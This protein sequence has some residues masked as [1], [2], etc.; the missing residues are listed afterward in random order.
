MLH[1]INLAVR[2]RSLAHPSLL[3]GFLNHSDS[4]IFFDNDCR[5]T[6]KKSGYKI[7]DRYIVS[8]KKELKERINEEKVD[9]KR[10]LKRFQKG[11]IGRALEERENTLKGLSRIF[12]E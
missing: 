11:I 8:S 6:L 1:L 7:A 9:F 5:S 10:S 3:A 4:I 12:F 2:L